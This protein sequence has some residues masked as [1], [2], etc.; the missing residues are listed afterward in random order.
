MSTPINHHSEHSSTYFVQEQSHKLMREELARLDFQSK[1]LTAEMGG[2]LPEQPDPA[3]FQH[4]L[5]LGSGT[6]DWLIETA[7]AYPTM[8]E[9]LGVDINPRMVSHAQTMARAQGVSD[10]VRFQTMDVLKT[11]ALGSDQFDLVNQRLGHSYIRTWE[12]PLLLGEC[13]RVS[14]PGGSIRL[15]EVET[16]PKSNSSA[17][18][19][20]GGL[21]ISALYEAGHSFTS[22][23]QGIT[24][25]LDRLLQQAGLQQVQTRISPLNYRG[26][27]PEGERFA[28][29]WQQLLRTTLPFVRKWARVP[30]NYEQMY[31]EA[32]H[33]MQQADFVATWNLL[34]AWG[35][36]PEK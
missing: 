26:K 22:D 20:L 6:G 21:L 36:T 32:V 28:Q 24:G 4:V 18:T 27:T 34:T 14:K 19:Q 5:D 30:E 7:K 15:I 9:L 31:D 35:V 33:D 1:M 25:H 3:I 2:V 29:G 8:N 12:W 16:V 23:T 13:Q 11:F 10:R 17:V